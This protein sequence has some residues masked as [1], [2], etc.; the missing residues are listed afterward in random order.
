MRPTRDRPHLRLVTHDDSRIPGFYRLTRAERRRLLGQRAGL[1]EEDFATWDGGGVD[2]ALADRVVEN[3]VGVH[4]L[5]LGVAVNFLVN[6]R[7]TFVPMAI[8]EPSVI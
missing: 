3:A 2:A 4:A 8:E 7:D 1:G 6:G 5:P